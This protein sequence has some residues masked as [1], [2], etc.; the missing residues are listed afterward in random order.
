MD[1]L[2][3]TFREVKDG[4]RAGRI[5]G[6]E[7]HPALR[8]KKAKII[9][10]SLASVKKSASRSASAAALESE[11]YA[12]FERLIMQDPDGAKFAKALQE[13]GTENQAKRRVLV[14]RLIDRSAVKAIDLDGD[15]QSELIIYFNGMAASLAGRTVYILRRQ[16]S[17][18][19]CIGSFPAK[20]FPQVTHP[21]P[22]GKTDEDV[23]GYAALESLG[24]S[25]HGYVVTS[26]YLFK[27]GRYVRVDGMRALPRAG[28]GYPA[29]AHL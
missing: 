28:R 11:V 13:I 26:R 18:W 19:N 29:S 2:K 16:E 3:L 21:L 12:I 20:S 27:K 1:L 7:T 14:D 22:S 17:E 6:L 23:E 25:D 24:V 15:G 9:A 10:L 4:F 8:M 5:C